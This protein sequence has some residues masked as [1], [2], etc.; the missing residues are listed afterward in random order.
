MRARARDSWPRN[1]DGRSHMP[2]IQV[3][4]FE[5]LLSKTEDLHALRAGV[6][7]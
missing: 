4:V 2:L 6:T 5:E 7:V 1:D 3:K